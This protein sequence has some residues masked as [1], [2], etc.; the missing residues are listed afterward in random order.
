MSDKTGIEWTDATWNPIRGCSRV[1][2]G[3]K[4][5]Y[6]EGQA[7]RIISM[8]RGRG[9]P[10]GEGSYD[11]LLAKGGQWNGQ[12][13]V[14]HSVMDQPLRWAKPR[15]IFVNSMSDLF[16]ENVAVEVIDRI[17]AV[18]LAC[19]T[20][21]NRKHTFQVLTK[22]PERMREYMLSRT[23]S[24]HI[25]AW[26]KAGDGLVHLKDGDVFFS[27]YVYGLVSHDWDEKGENSSGSEYKPW[28]YTSKLFPL[29]NV[30]LG[31]SVENQAAADERIPLLLETPAAVRWL[32]MEPLLGPVDLLATPA[33]D[34]LCRCE[35]CMN[36]ARSHP[37]SGGLQRI[38]WV[39]VGGESGP[40][41]RPMHPEWATQ[42][43]DQCT[44]N[45]VPF[46]FKQ[47]GEWVPRS[48]CFH[49]FE[50]GKSCGDY[51]PQCERWPAVVRL[52][53]Q[54]QNGRSLSADTSGGS[55]AYMQRVGKKFAGRLL[56]GQ[57][58]DG[59]P[60]AGGSE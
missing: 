57:L 45:G 23:P 4:H 37:D 9:I 38:D 60:L 21:D 26:A 10:E 7:A 1:S 59:Y 28:G 47:W 51:D 42:L 15:L 18:M 19:A 55:E 54:G 17:F 27:E 33:G 16:H 24:E 22:R 11:G 44:S 25:Q 31:V 49:T 12:I 30:W 43:R 20:L 52:T 32:S 53:Y 39:V 8:D 58:H 56:K 35:G 46:L 5:C 2:D 3:C 6:A 40:K 41:A 29:P 34:I 13:K 36:M 14:V 48:A 50:D